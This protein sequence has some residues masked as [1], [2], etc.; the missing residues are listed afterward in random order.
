[1]AEREKNQDEWRIYTWWME[2]G[3]KTQAFL[4]FA[5]FWVS[6]CVVWMS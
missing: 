3:P 1:M 4:W 5:F 2:L 6:I